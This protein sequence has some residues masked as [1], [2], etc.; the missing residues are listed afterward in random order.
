MV[1]Q[2]FFLRY[3]IQYCFVSNGF[4]LTDLVHRLSVFF[5]KRA[6]KR[7]E[8]DSV[9]KSRYMDTYEYDIGYHQSYTLVMFLC[10]L[11]FA[12]P[13]PL[14]GFVAFL[15]FL[16][17]YYIDKYNLVF[18]YFKVY[19]SNG[20]IRRV[21]VLYLRIIVMIYLCIT[22]GFFYLKFDK[23]EYFYGGCVM[24]GIWMALSILIVTELKKLYNLDDKLKTKTL[25]FLPAKMMQQMAYKKYKARISKDSITDEAFINSTDK[26]FKKKMAII[27]AYNEKQ[28]TQAYTHPF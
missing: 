26:D 19:E 12:I 28:L 13:V 15:L 2:F 6:H 24:I 10:V 16:I 22:V 21:V 27:Q 5:G 7:K 4:Y 17:K 1:A 9:I 11:V 8:K 18:V 25:Q 3:M 20:D 14:I 23:I